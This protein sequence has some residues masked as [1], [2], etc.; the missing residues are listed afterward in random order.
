MKNDR[1]TLKESHKLMR[2]RERMELA[3]GELLSQIQRLK[4]KRGPALIVRAVNAHDEL[5]WSADALIRV[6]MK[7]ITNNVGCIT[8]DDAFV[9]VKEARN[10]LAKSEGLL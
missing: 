6:V 9:I 2:N 10:A 3:E 5:K 7:Y 8:D 1:M 4:E